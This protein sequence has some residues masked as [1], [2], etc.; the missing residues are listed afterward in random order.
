MSSVPRPSAAARRASLP[1]PSSPLL[2]FSRS[3]PSPASSPALS[4]HD[5]VAFADLQGQFHRFGQPRP[6]RRLD[7]QPVHDHFDV[8]PHLAVQLQV[9]GQRHHVA[10]DASPDEALLQQVLEQVA[11]LAFLAADQRGEH[12]QPGSFGQMQDPG[13]D[14]LAGLSRDGLAAFGAVALADAGEQHA[15][16]VVD[17][18]DRADGGTRDWRRWISAR[19]KSRDSSRRCS[20]RPASASGPGIG[21]RN[22][23]GSPRTA[24]GLR[25][26]AYRTPAN[27]C[28][29]R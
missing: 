18:R 27:S 8:V 14:L 2:P 29:T 4:R 28:P 3:P 19:W 22:W 12:G 26:T 17:L 1:V 25:R 9:V 10:V 24:A 6:D 5:Q 7:H 20:P 11:I 23:T 13:D 16:I 21:G 15:Q